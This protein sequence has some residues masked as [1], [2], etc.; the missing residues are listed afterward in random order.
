MA[1][2]F[3]LVVLMVEILIIFKQCVFLPPYLTIQDAS[4]PERRE[5][6]RPPRRYLSLVAIGSAILLSLVVLKHEQRR[7]DSN[8]SLKGMCVR[9]EG[10]T[11]GY[12]Q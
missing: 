2:T 9:M 8:E 10:W 7:A 11:G 1:S 6:Q 4:L 5:R 12:T 3:Y